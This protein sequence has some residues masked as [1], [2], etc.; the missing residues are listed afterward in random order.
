MVHT[1]TN[2]TTGTHTNATTKTT[3]LN[4]KPSTPDTTTVFAVI[5]AVWGCALEVKAPE[6]SNPG[7]GVSNLGLLL[8]YN[9][10]YIRVVL[11]LYRDNG[12][13]NGNHYSILVLCA[14]CQK[15]VWLQSVGLRFL[16]VVLLD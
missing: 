7:L 13:G 12:K 1:A 16:E 6:C 15:C 8:Q 4:F 5:L 2:T 3:I 11:G 10:V 9:R 14:C